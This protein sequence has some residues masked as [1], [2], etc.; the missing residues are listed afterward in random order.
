MNVETENF[1]D[2]T[3]ALHLFYNMLDLQLKL[4]IWESLNPRWWQKQKKK[5]QCLPEEGW[6]MHHLKHFVNEGKKTKYSNTHKQIHTG[7]P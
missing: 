5:I 4:F 6:R 1:F 3:I 2:S 7:E